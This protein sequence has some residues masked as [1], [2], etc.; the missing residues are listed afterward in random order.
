MKEGVLIVA[1]VSGHW[2]HPRRGGGGVGRR[3]AAPGEGRARG[4]ARGGRAQFGWRCRGSI[5]WCPGSRF[6]ISSQGE[7]ISRNFRAWAFSNFLA[8]APVCGPSRPSS[9]STLQFP[10]SPT[11]TATVSLP[12]PP[13]MVLSVGVAREHCLGVIGSRQQSGKRPRERGTPSPDLG[14][15]GH[16]RGKGGADSRFVP[17]VCVCHS[18]PHI[19]PIDSQTQ[20]NSTAY[21]NPNTPFGTHPR[22][23]AAAEGTLALAPRGPPERGP[24]CRAAAPGPTARRPGDTKKEKIYADALGHHLS[25]SHPEG[26]PEG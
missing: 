17:G 4:A 26:P 1:C 18:K 8:V 14:T 22:P 12:W 21:L 2:W 15:R 19:H 25:G 24:A 20:L 9:Y 23:T 5:V 3:G 11:A 10:I 13:S 16:H 6:P 7:P